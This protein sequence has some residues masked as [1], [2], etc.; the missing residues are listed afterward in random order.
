M[1]DDR[2]VRPEAVLKTLPP[3]QQQAVFNIIEST[4]YAAALKLLEEQ[5]S[6]HTSQAA[7]SMFRAWYLKRKLRKDMLDSV[8]I[9]DVID[10]K[11]DEAALDRA[12]AIKTKDLAWRALLAGH[13]KKAIKSLVDLSLDMRVED[14]QDKKLER[15][16]AAERQRD[17]ALKQ[18]AE[19][20]KR[21]GDLLEQLNRRK[22][23]AEEADPSKAMEALELFLG[24]KPKP[25][26]APLTSNDKP[27]PE[28]APGG[29]PA[30]TESTVADAPAPEQRQAAPDEQG[31]SQSHPG[32]ALQGAP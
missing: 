2:K 27:Q 20:E 16:L 29:A 28:H 23:G 12:I 9:A 3:E 22:Q 26:P 13:D 17:A 8:R 30:E 31:S 14:R 10:K 32:P 24:T 11:V 18:L 19:V 1:S 7:L 5:L 6:L 15:L 4:T 25:Q 21:V